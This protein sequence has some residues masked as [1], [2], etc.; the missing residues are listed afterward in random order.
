MDYY[1]YN[2]VNPG[3][4]PGSIAKRNMPFSREEYAKRLADTKQ[5]MGRHG[6]DALIVTDPA[7]ICYLSGYAASSAY[8]AQGLVVFADEGEPH[9]FLRRQ[10]APAAMY[11]TGISNDR[12]HGYPERYIGDYRVSGFDY[13]IDALRE[14]GGIRSVGLEFGSIAASS[15]E[16]LRNRFSDLTFTNMAGE[17]ELIRLVKSP[18]EL[19]CLRKA[20]KITEAV[21]LQL[22][23]SFRAGRHECEAAADVQAALMRGLPDI[24]G[25]PTDTVFMPGGAQSGTSHI[26]WRDRMIEPGSHYNA[27]YAG[28]HHRYHAPIMRTISIGKPSDKLD[29]MYGYMVDGCNEALAAVRPGVTCADVARKYCQILD[30]GGYWKDSRCGYPIGINWLETSCSLRVD[31]PTELKAGMAFHLMLGTWLEEDFG[32]V[33][34]EAFIVTEDGHEVLSHVPRGI[35]VA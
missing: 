34:S 6:V 23:E 27:E 31:D 7:N 21:T 19:D 24:P 32:A 26:T 18:A 30:K 9:F 5:A 15:L 25:E 29:R 16:T 12:I 35:V 10:D 13:I 3:A 22:A 28:A 11:M 17:I 14:H 1:E 8:V 2:G 4:F 33:I 20:G